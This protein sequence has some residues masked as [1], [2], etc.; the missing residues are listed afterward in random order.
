MVVWLG[1]GMSHCPPG[2]A[3]ERLRKDMLRGECP[4]F[5]S[6]GSIAML[7]PSSFSLQ[8]APSWTAVRP[9]ACGGN[10]ADP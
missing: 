4:G 6:S 9:V 10:A 8:A 1:K 5:V 7:S 2:Q 3:V